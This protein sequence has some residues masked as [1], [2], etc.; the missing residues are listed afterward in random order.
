MVCGHIEN[1]GNIRRHLKKHK[2]ECLCKKRAD[3]CSCANFQNSKVIIDTL[4]LSESEK[5]E[6]Q[7]NTKT[8]NKNRNKHEENEVGS[9]IF[10]MNPIETHSLKKH[11]CV[12][13][14]KWFKHNEGLNEHKKRACHLNVIENKKTKFVVGKETITNK[15]YNDLL[16]EKGWISDAVGFKIEFNFLFLIFF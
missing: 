7:I 8:K 10:I 6:S 14:N 9:E 4:E 12:E 16:S 5:T 3:S 13:C 2:K 1:N 11:H 15:N